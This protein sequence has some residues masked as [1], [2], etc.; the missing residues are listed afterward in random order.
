MDNYKIFYVYNNDKKMTL[1]GTSDSNKNICEIK[2]NII[3]PFI[4]FR[5][6]TDKIKFIQQ[7]QNDDV[8]SGIYIGNDNE[9]DMAIYIYGKRDGWIEIKEYTNITIS[10]EEIPEAKYL[11]YIIA[12]SYKDVVNEMKYKFIKA[13][14]TNNKPNCVKL[15]EHQ[16]MKT[17]DCYV[18]Q[19]YYYTILG[20][21]KSLFKKK[22]YD[23][24]IIN[25]VNDI[26]MGKI[27]CIRFFVLVP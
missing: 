8:N 12:K 16:Y 2:N 4:S 24:E 27:A 19:N 18:E 3:K 23:V 21:A 20:I 10:D 1:L 17:N 6:G 11:H 5:Y 26:Q 14:S 22:G 7:I 13:Y 15:F 9:K 25:N